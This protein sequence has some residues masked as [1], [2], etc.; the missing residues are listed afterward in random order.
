MAISVTDG[1][2]CIINTYTYIN[3]PNAWGN[4]H[5]EDPYGFCE[6][7]GIKNRYRNF[8]EVKFLHLK[9]PS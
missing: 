3:K 1:T 4:P 9:L 6:V 8:F 5:L 2:S 7:P